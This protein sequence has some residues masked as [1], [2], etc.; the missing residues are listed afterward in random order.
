MHDLEAVMHDLH[1]SVRPLHK[2]KRG[3]ERQQERK[4][5]HL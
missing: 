3:E 1:P 2:E 4:A 5:G